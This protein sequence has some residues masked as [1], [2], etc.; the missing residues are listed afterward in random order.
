MRLFKIVWRVHTQIRP[1]LI[2]LFDHPAMKN[3]A[4]RVST[5]EQW[6]RVFRGEI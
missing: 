1:I 4:V 6:T 3:K 5:T 2:D